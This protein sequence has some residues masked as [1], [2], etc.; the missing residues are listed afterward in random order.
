[1]Q[2]WKTKK[3]QVSQKLGKAEDDIITAVHLIFDELKKSYESKIL[4]EERILE[5]Q[6][7]GKLT[8]FQKMCQSQSESL[9]YYSS[10]LKDGTHSSFFIKPLYTDI[11]P[12]CE[13]TVKNIKKD[14]DK[15]SRNEINLEYEKQILINEIKNKIVDNFQLSLV[16]FEEDDN[17]DELSRNSQA[18]K[19][20]KSIVKGPKS[21]SPNIKYTV[22]P[23]EQRQTNFI[24]RAP[25]L[26]SSSPNWKVYY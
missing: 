16:Y 5:K 20:T 7:G 22:S 24:Q 8:E 18:F 14:F 4:E 17:I 3:Q 15:L 1:M 11:I 25:L 23:L 26:T 19:Q 10:Q 12:Q 13:E 6:F 2:D 21:V 9:D